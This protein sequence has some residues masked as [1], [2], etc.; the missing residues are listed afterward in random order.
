MKSILVSSVILAGLAAVQVALARN[1]V[2]GVQY[3]GKDLLSIGTCFH[4][5]PP[6]ST[7]ITFANASES[8]ILTPMTLTGNYQ[9]LVNQ[10]LLDN[11]IPTTKPRGDFLF[12]CYGTSD[13]LLDFLGDCG[14]GNCVVAGANE[15][16]FC[17][18]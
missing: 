6:P 2:P 8:R 5:S 12:L 18:S 4:L 10:C 15:D 3:C 16:D 7:R 17:S 1:C 11:G 9:E 14:P 13:G